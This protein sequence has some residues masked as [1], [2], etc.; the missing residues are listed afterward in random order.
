M[1]FILPCWDVL[2]V[3]QE[4]LEFKNQCLK[5][6]TPNKAISIGIYSIEGLDVGFMRVG[7][8]I[9]IYIYITGTGRPRCGYR[10]GDRDMDRDIDID[11]DT[12]KDVDIATGAR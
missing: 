9:Y 10:Y 6:V 12:G 4:P 1:K 11:T 2:L 5:M 3:T 8:S 7:G